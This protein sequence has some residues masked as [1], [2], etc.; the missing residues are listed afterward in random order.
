SSLS[1]SAYNAMRPRSGGIDIQSFGIAP[2]PDISLALLVRAARPTTANPPA[3]T[4]FIRSHRLIRRI[5]K[6]VQFALRA[7][8]L[9]GQAQR[10]PVTDHLMRKQNPLLFGDDADQILLDIH[11]V[12]VFRE[13]QPPRDA[14]HMRVDHDSRRDSISS[15]QHDV[16]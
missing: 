2:W 3:S 9:P 8:G 4:I 1:Y 5:T 11:G 15:A 6:R 12:V 13:V 7:P 14:Q 16:R 10:A